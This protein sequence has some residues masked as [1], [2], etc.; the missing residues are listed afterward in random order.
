MRYYAVKQGKSKEPVEEISLTSLDKRILEVSRDGA[1][2]SLLLVKSKNFRTS[3]GMKEFYS[4]SE[5]ASAVR[6]LLRHGL[7]V[8]R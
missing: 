3:L 5:I 6:K 7:L 8:R 2:I 4:S 1:G